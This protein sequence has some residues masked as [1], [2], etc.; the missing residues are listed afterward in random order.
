MA[1]CPVCGVALPVA[2]NARLNTHIDQCLG[3]APAAAPAQA[4][5]ARGSAQKKRK[6]AASGGGPDRLQRTLLASWAR[7]K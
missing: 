4:A 2:D 6:A 3:Q 1:A 7:P 5:A